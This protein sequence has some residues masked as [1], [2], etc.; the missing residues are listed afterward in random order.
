M[1]TKQIV[2]AGQGSESQ[3]NRH[4]QPL[5]YNSSEQ[6]AQGKI[7]ISNSLRTNSNDFQ[8]SQILRYDTI[9]M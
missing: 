7:F 9:D 2:L 3:D 6:C 4:Q 8:S 1:S 5:A